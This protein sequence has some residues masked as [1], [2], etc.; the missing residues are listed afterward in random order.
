MAFD[1]S[2]LS[3]NL[4]VVF[5]LQI[6]I[7]DQENSLCTTSNKISLVKV[8]SLHGD[9]EESLISPHDNLEPTCH[10][11]KDIPG[12]KEC[13]VVFSSQAWGRYISNIFI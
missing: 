11:D 10:P 4:T 7:K 6:A 5:L 13:T 12:K 9:L 2:D 1:L 3:S 8:S